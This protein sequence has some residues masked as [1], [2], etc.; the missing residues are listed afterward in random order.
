MRESVNQA[1]TYWNGELCKARIVSVIV[2]D[3]GQFPAYWARDFVGQRRR[4]VEVVYAGE[5]F[6][7]DDQGYE[8]SEREREALSRHGR[9]AP[10]RCGFPGWGWVK[11]TAG[12]GS[13]GWAHASLE[14]VPGS[15]EPWWG[16]AWLRER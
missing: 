16:D 14:I 5:T 8:T 2:A 12:R 7:I 10:K 15:V 13:P 4:A 3:N 1:A 11:V 6:Y 9:P